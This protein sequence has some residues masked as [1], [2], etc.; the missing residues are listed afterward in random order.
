[1]RK[2]KTI[3]PKDY[4]E[5]SPEAASNSK[6]NNTASVISPVNSK[7]EGNLSVILT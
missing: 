3:T 5:D 1:M 6:I 7:F 2:S 4:S